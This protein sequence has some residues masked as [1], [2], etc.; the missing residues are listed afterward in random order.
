MEFFFLSS[1]HSFILL[2]II[3]IAN[4]C[5]IFIIVTYFCKIHK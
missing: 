1:L 3:A 4:Y 5:S 2:R